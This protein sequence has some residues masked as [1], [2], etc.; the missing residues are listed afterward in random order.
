MNKTG[1]VVCAGIHMSDVP[2][3]LSRL[4][5]KE[6]PLVYVAYLARQDR[7]DLMRLASIMDLVMRMT[8]YPLQKAN[9]AL[10]DLLAGRLEGPAV[11]VP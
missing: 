6:L 8:A 3:F 7:L 4:L 9:Q 1:R 11:L 5:W 2:G 10:A